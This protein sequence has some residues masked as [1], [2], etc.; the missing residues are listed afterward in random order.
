[1]S[2]YIKL[3]RSIWH[4]HDFVALPASTQRLYLLL[5]SQPDLSHCG[6]VAYTPGRWS[7]LAVDTSPA[8]IRSDVERLVVARFVMLDE[9]T[10]ELWVRSYMSH[11]GGYRTPN[12]H[13]PIRTAIAGIMSNLIREQVTTLAETLGV[14]LPETVTERVAETLPE[15][16]KPA[17]LSH[18]PSTSSQQ[19]PPHPLPTRPEPVDLRITLSDAA[20]AAAEIW[21]AHRIKQPGVKHPARL[22]TVLRARLT[23]EYGPAL[24]QH[25]QQHPDASIEQILWEIFHL[26]PKGTK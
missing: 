22:A 16:P 18:K 3:Q 17:A 23:D 20:A 13:K 9:R 19:P 6:V 11:D 12:I 2:G 21:I 7:T 24:T 1:M 25:H 4:D 26:N 14:T 8:D 15:S 10:E 5:I